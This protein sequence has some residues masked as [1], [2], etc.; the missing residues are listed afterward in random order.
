MVLWLHLV[1]FKK[2]CLLLWFLQSESLGVNVSCFTWLKLVL[3]FCKAFGLLIGLSLI[4]W[5]SSKGLL[6]IRFVLLG[7]LFSL[8]D[9]GLETF[10]LIKESKRFFFFL[11]AFNRYH[12]SP[13][14]VN[15][16]L[17]LLGFPLKRLRAKVGFHYF[18]IKPKTPSSV[19]RWSDHPRGYLMVHGCVA[20]RSGWEYS[21]ISWVIRPF[22]RDLRV[23]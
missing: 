20:F 8:K 15:L 22:S 7:C 9:E 23:V 21:C 18:Q 14:V 10:L 11:E 4:A 6:G 2:K 1:V 16:Q 5:L 17:F 13:S 19:I 12:L 3:W